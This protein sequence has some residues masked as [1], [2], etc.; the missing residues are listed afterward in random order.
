MFIQNI[1]IVED[2]S[3]FAEL[4]IL[5]LK[6]HYPN[7][8]LQHF[9]SGEDLLA[10]DDVADL[11]ILDYDLNDASGEAKMTGLELRNA[12][13]AK[14]DQTPTIFLT[15]MQNIGDAVFMMENHASDF[16]VKNRSSLDNLITTIKDLEDIVELDK[17]KKTITS[18]SNDHKTGW[19]LVAAA[20]I[21]LLLIFAIFSS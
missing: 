12:L 6:Q 3:F 16:I 15:G 21:V 20:L 1:H 17:E 2:D 5:K 18:T 19:K 9:L 8:T 11:L 13:Q 7:I 14:G 4:I 10:Q